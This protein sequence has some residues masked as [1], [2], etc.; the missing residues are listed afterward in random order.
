[1]VTARIT[2]KGQITVPKAV[3]EYLGVE[4]GDALE[5]EIR[6]DEQRVEVR[7]V[8]RRSV[9]EFQGMF[10]VPPGH[11]GGPWKQVRQRAW[12]T[13]TRRLTGKPEVDRDV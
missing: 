7:P 11:S 12:Q 9:K 6:D 13:A 10:P 5:F 2:S 8:R 1:M 4:S 3:R